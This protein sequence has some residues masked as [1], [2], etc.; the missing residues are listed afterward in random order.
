VRPH[1]TLP[2]SLYR[3]IHDRQGASAQL[4]RFELPPTDT[5]FVLNPLR[6][7]ERAFRALLYVL[8]VFVV[9]IA[10]VLIVRAVS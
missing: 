3:L 6:T 10:V 9:A 7:E 8:G 4:A 1:T 5:A 2:A